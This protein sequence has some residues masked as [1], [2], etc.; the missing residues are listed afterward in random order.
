MEI[1]AIVEMQVKPDADAATVESA[2]KKISARTEKHD[3]GTVAHKYFF[4]PERTILIV[5]E[6]YENA[7]AMQEHLSNMD[8]EV[9]ETLTSATN[10]VSNRIFGELPAELKAQLEEFGGAEFFDFVSGFNRKS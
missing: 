2:A 4:N 8:P 6:H 1:R 10:V 7:E 5:H 9:V 3:L